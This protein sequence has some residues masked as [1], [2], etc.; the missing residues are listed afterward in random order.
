MTVLLCCIRSGVIRCTLFM[1]LYLW[2]MCPSM[3]RAVVWSHIDILMRLL[4]AEPS[5]TEGPLFQ[6][7]C[8]C[9][10]IWLTLYSIVWD[11][12]I[13]RARPM[14]FYW[15]SCWIIFCL[16]LFFLSLSLSAHWPGILKAARWRL[17][18]CSKSCNLQPALHS[19][20]RGAH[21]VLPCVG[22]GVRPVN[23]IYR[24]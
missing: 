6:S 7:Q 24:L 19:A 17:A 9:G 5:S 2:R 13:S 21:G 12:L 20:I 15:P 23:W 18:E 8:P 4:A 3:L 10:T 22:W 11:R 14:L 1:V 16:L